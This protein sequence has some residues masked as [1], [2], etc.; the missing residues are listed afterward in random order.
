MSFYQFSKLASCYSLV[1]HHSEF[2][3]KCL[4]SLWKSCLCAQGTAYKLRLHLLWVC[5]RKDT[6]ILQ[7]YLPR[8]LVR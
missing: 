1:L 8:L 3:L 2:I 5:S 7:E 4:H 6:N